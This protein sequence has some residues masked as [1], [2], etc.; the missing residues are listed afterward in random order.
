MRELDFFRQLRD[1]IETE[2]DRER[3]ADFLCFVDALEGQ[4]WDDL[5]RLQT[6]LNKS[7][8]EIDPLKVEF[9]SFLRAFIRS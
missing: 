7:D 3:R 6:L 4:F 9:L 2:S 8:S 5:A 1:A